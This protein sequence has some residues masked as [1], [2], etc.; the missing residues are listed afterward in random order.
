MRTASPRASSSCVRMLHFVAVMRPHAIALVLTLAA[1][2]RDGDQPLRRA[3][4]SLLSSSGGDVTLSDGSTLHFAITSDRYKQ[5]EQA[6]A[7][8]RSNVTERFG[9]LLHPDAPTSRSV[10]RAVAFLETDA[11][12]REAI[13]RTGM[14]VRDFVLMTIALQQ[15]MR[16]ASQRG[17]APS[18][19]VTP[20]EPSPVDSVVVPDSPYRATT[21]VFVAPR[22]LVDTTTRIDSVRRLPN[23]DSIARVDTFAPRPPSRDT[24]L[25][26]RRDTPRARKDSVPPDSITSP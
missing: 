8:L 26:P 14:S 22:V 6:R 3:D 23:P 5:W 2:G 18:A 13:E 21:P 11:P 9:Q 12:S 1:C 7:A 24:L 4:G 25:A 15:E 10:D 16:L 20:P 19:A 17:S